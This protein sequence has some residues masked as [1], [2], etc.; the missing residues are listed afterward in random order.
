LVKISYPIKNIILFP[1]RFTLAGLWFLWTLAVGGLYPGCAPIFF[2]ERYILYLKRK[3]FNKYS[4]VL[5]DLLSRTGELIYQSSVPIDKYRLIDNE[6]VCSYFINGEINYSVIDIKKRSTNSLSSFAAINRNCYNLLNKSVGAIS[7][8]RICTKDMCYQQIIMTTVTCQEVLENHLEGIFCLLPTVSNDD[9]YISYSTSNGIYIS[10]VLTKK[11]L[12]YP[13]GESFVYNW[14]NI[15]NLLAY[16]MENSY[17]LLINPTVCQKKNIKLPDEYANRKSNIMTAAI[18]PNGNFIAYGILGKVKGS[19]KDVLLILQSVH[20]GD[21][22][23]LAKKACIFSIGWSEKEKYIS[24]AGVSKR[25][26]F[27]ISYGYKMRNAT[28]HDKEVIDIDGN[29]IMRS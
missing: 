18:S 8:H 13:E 5:Y 17:F 21:Y 2:N 3:G 14:D 25:D 19:A 11:Q 4:V 28:N 16:S 7:V 24:I 9:R 15:G 10:N 22:K 12:F 27:E 29:S 26:L 23:V 6:L 1:I 20:T